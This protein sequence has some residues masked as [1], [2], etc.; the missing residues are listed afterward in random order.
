MNDS[1]RP[2]DLFRRIL[3]QTS[4]AMPPTSPSSV[5]LVP[6][7]NLSR[8]TRCIP[9]SYRVDARDCTSLDNMYV[10]R[11]LVREQRLVVKAF[12]TDDVLDVEAVGNVAHEG[13]LRAETSGLVAPHR[14]SR[15][16]SELVLGKAIEIA[17]A[18]I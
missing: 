15:E 16:R 4:S 8:E 13:A 11:P 2:A 3:R 12:E 5:F 18:L 6:A 10:F 9:A 7:K 14:V 17:A 1:G